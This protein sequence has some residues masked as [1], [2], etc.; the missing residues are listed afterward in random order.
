MQCVHERIFLVGLMGAGKSTVGALLASRLNR[1]YID[2]DVELARAQGQDA[3][4][5][6]QRGADALHDAEATYV[7]SLFVH[8]GPFVAA[9]PASVADLVTLATAVNDS[10]FVVYL[11]AHPDVLAD[12]VVSDPE[13]PWLASEARATLHAMFGKRDSVFRETSDLQIEVDVL[14]PDAIVDLVVAAFSTAP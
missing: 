5:L 3:V 4:T 10:G 14:S 9:L 13:R 8:A 2:N 6:A 1:E 7:E 12:R 11:R